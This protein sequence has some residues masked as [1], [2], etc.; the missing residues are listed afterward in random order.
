MV[1]IFQCY[2]YEVAAA[3]T[4]ASSCRRLIKELYFGCVSLHQN[5]AKDGSQFGR[6]RANI[7]CRLQRGVSD[8]HINELVSSDSLHT[9]NSSAGASRVAAEVVKVAVV[10]PGHRERCPAPDVVKLVC[11]AALFVRVAGSLSESGMGMLTML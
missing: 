9:W 4:S 1:A 5:F 2:S 3:V 8:S 6:L 7:H 10:G 11:A